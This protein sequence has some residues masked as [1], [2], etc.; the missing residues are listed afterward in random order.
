MTVRMTT[1]AS[2]EAGSASAAPGSNAAASCSAQSSEGCLDKL[3]STR[4]RNQPYGKEPD[5][6]EDR[7][8]SQA[9]GRGPTRSTPSWL[10]P[11]PTAW[12]LR[13]SSPE[14]SR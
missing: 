1:R 4:P 12:C 6:M 10:L 14:C 11:A 13:M 9:S 7:V 2:D 3:R 5:K 8:K